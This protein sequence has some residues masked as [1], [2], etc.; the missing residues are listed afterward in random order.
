MFLHSSLH[1]ICLCCQPNSDT[2]YY[3]SGV[4]TP[5]YQQGRC[6]DIK[7]KEKP[8]THMAKVHS[9]ENCPVLY[10]KLFQDNSSFAAKM[11]PFL[12]GSACRREVICF[13]DFLSL[14]AKLSDDLYIYMFQ[15][16]QQQ[17]T[18]STSNVPVTRL[19]KSQILSHSLKSS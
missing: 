5:A 4:D 2:F 1:S 12:Q 10:W 11:L 3:L 16:S 9:K 14:L 6:S 8:Q 19:R 7:L 18:L 13:S 15:L 17:L